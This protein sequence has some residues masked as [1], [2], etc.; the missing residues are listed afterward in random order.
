M[1]YTHDTTSSS[2]SSQDQPLCSG[3]FT[4]PLQTFNNREYHISSGNHHPQRPIARESGENRN[5]ERANPYLETYVP[6]LSGLTEPQP[7]FG[8]TPD[9]TFTRA[10]AVS[11]P[12]GPGRLHTARNGFRTEFQ[13]NTALN[14]ATDSHY[15]R[16]ASNFTN[17]GRYPFCWGARK[18]RKP[19]LYG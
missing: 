8:V 1:I 2:S 12:C 7:Y 11:P 15:G 19:Q 14:C 9:L 3:K 10:P 4:E 5:Q 17:K 16:F 6:M 13:S 18:S